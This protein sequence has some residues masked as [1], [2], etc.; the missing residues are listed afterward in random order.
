MTLPTTQAPSVT[1]ETGLSMQTRLIAWVVAVT[2]FMENLDAT[3]IA[4]ALPTM[5]AFGVTPF[6]LNVGITAY[7]LAVAVFIPLSSWIISITSVP[8]PISVSM[9]SRAW[10]TEWLSR[11]PI[12]RT[13]RKSANCCTVRKPWSALMRVTPGPRSVKSTRDVRSFGKLQ[14]DEAL[15]KA[16]KTQ[17]PV[18]SDT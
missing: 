10:C 15:T 6:D 16:W 7:I 5:A 18:Q 8:K 4:T 3:V 13:S 12:L 11:R 1:T 17:C 14:P 2:F 9:T